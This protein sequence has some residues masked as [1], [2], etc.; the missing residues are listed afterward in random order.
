M[1]LHHEPH[2]MEQGELHN[3]SIMKLLN[4]PSIQVT[5]SSLWVGGSDPGS[6]YGDVRFTWASHELHMSSSNKVQPTQSTTF[7]P[8]LVE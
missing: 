6:D 2:N 4:T 8:P 5:P 7:K 3:G 1:C